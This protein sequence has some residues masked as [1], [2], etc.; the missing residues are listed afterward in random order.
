MDGELLSRGRRFRLG[1]GQ[2]LRTQMSMEPTELRTDEEYRPADA[3]IWEVPGKTIRVEIDFDLMDRLETEVMQAFGSVPRR[4]L[5][6]GGVLLGTVDTGETNR[7]R[8]ED[9][10]PVLSKHEHGPSY[11]LSGPELEQLGE[12]TARWR[13]RNGRR[14]RVVGFFRSHTR[15]GLGLSQEDLE[16]FSQ[17]FPE[18][19]SVAL[20]VKPYATRPPVAGLFFREEAAIRSQAS[21]QEFPFRRRELGGA[22]R[23]RDK[24]GPANGQGAVRGPFERTAARGPDTPASQGNVDSEPPGPSVPRRTVNLRGGWIW[25]PL[26]VIFLLLGTALGFQISLAVRSQAGPGSDQDPYALYL[27]ATPSAD[28][29]HVSWD[30]SSPVLRVAKS[31]V[32]VITDNGTERRVEL[33]FAQLRNGSVVYSRASG[34]LHF[35][36]EVRTTRDA[37]VAEAVSYPAV[38]GDER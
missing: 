14:T 15:E 12:I 2:P 7:V 13:A 10:E 35:R 8:I 5:E 29:V 11:V 24:P 23:E 4:G 1:L 19:T 34:D 21:Y 33:N 3:Y 22:A 28:S 27:A 6:V 38:P 36:L 20:V 32:L 30:R 9:F 31:G 17:Y 18:E 26:S 37:I 25:I 16:L